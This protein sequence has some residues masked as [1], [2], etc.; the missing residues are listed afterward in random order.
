MKKVLSL[1]L[2]VSLLFGCF[3][4]SAFAAEP[5]DILLSRTVEVLDNGDT[6]VTELYENALQPRTGKTGHKT[7]THYGSNG[8]AI[9]AV[10]VNGTFVYTG[11]SSSATGSTATVNIY[12][13]NAVYQSKNAWTSGN[14]AWASGTVKYDSVSATHNVNISCDKYGVLS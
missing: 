2:V 4:I 6:V 7:V 13:S 3:S 11:V 8:S 12:N 5:E 1:L 14:T 10:T 9:W